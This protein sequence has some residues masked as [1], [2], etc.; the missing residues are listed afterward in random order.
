ME[1]LEA[2]DR[3]I[4]DPGQYQ[5]DNLYALETNGG[6]TI[7]EK[8]EKKHDLFEK[9]IKDLKVNPKESIVIDDRV[10]GIVAAKLPKEIL[11]DDYQTTRRIS[12]I[13]YGIFCD[14]PGGKYSGDSYEPG[15]PDYLKHDITVDNLRKVP[16]ILANWGLG[17]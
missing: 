9:A 11:E 5:K 2:Y 1:L 16:K 17:K 15:V 7:Q 3:K 10:Y 8:T 14:L 6:M 13:K 4:I 12:G